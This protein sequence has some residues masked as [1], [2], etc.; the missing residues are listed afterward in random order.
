MNPKTLAKRTHKLTDQHRLRLSDIQR[1]IGAALLHLDQAD[2]DANH[3]A[4][5][6]TELLEVRGALEQ[7]VDLLTEA[8]DHL[9][10]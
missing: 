3:G 2:E 1:E 4:D 6:V 9:P 10:K 5:P 7:S 8:I